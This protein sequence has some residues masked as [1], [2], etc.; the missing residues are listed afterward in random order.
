MPHLLIRFIIDVSAYHVYNNVL[1]VSL[2]LL[3]AETAT[4]GC[5]YSECHIDK[6]FYLYVC[7]YAPV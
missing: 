5:A 3:W 7:Q 2:Q 4:V 6:T 1:Y